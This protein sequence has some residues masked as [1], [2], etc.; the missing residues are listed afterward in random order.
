MST[1][2]QDTALAAWRAGRKTKNSSKGWVSGNAVC[3]PH[4]GE[5]VDKRGRGGMIVNP[6][7]TVSYSCFNCQFH[8][9]YTPGYPLSWK[10][11]KLLK[12][13]N[14]D[15]N[16]IQRLVIDALREQQ[17]Q[18]M[19]GL[20]KVEHKK[21]EVKTNFKKESL[22]EGAVSFYGLVEFYE[23][24]NAGIDPN[25]PTPA[26][27]RPYPTG[28]VEAVTYVSDRKINMSKYDFYWTED[29]ISKMDKRV[30]IPFTWKNEIIGYSA[31]ALNEFIT[32]KYVQHIDTGYVFNMDKQE[33]DWTVVIV[34]E[35]V[36]DALSI[37]AVAVLKADVTTQQIDLIESL[38]KDIIVVPDWN[39]TG[40][41]LIDV[42][43]NNGWAVSFPVWAETCTDINQA[44]QK[45]GKLF[46]LKTIFDSVEK[47]ELK[48]KLLRK[49]YGSN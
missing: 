16:D 22:P 21:E 3:C 48:I 43:L 36:F 31:R 20:V 42:A 14:V 35:G 12:W 18:E 28:F 27:H 15:S 45:Y 29:T 13:L 41:N 47:S 10:F 19:L 33:K 44:V 7:G 24:A 32:P 49:K 34:C 2:I 26:H 23:L 38:D 46:V 25:Q 40:S 5:S 4:N 8:A 6:D 39:R 11:R 1:S 17:R 9:S 30:I 37:D